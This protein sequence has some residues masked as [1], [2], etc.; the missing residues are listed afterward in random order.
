MNSMQGVMDGVYSV[1]P[2]PWIAS[3]GREVMGADSGDIQIQRVGGRMLFRPGQAA[4]CHVDVPGV[5]ATF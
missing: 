5:V 4:V 3:D 2:R 1:S